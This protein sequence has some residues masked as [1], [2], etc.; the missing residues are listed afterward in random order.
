MMMV[1]RVGRE[2][3]PALGSHPSHTGWN[4]WFWNKCSIQLGL[5]GA[6]CITVILGTSSE[7]GLISIMAQWHILFMLIVTFQL[8]TVAVEL[9]EPSP[10]LTPS[11]EEFMVQWSGPRTVPE[12]LALLIELIEHCASLMANILRSI[13]TNYIFLLASLLAS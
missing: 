13:I 8:L 1:V 5:C 6:Q 11:G 10:L 3:R 2:V 9:S 12:S 4:W 7:R